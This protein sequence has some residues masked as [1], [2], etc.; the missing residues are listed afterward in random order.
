M[1]V[2]QNL[3]EL[4]NQLSQDSTYREVVRGILTNLE[5][6]SH[7]SIYELADLTSSSRTTIWRML[8]LLGYENYADFRRALK[9][10]VERYS[11]Y[12]RLLPSGAVKSDDRILQHIEK[13]MADASACLGSD[14]ETHPLSKMAK[15]VSEKK[16][17]FFF[18]SYRSPAIYSFQQN[19]A[20]AGIETC[21]VC[22]L[23]DMMSMASLA[24]SDTLV[25][26]SVIEHSETM[27]LVTLF[28]MLYKKKADVVLFAGEESYY[29]E[30][31]GDLIFSERNSTGV[32][33]AIL[34]TDLY[35][36]ALSDTFRKDY[37]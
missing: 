10:A 7:A 28:E 22:L 26:C 2:L 11:Y 4:Y 24:S 33:S 20:M 36:M 9:T 23:P 5:E 16:K 19:L 37:L 35:L 3:I 6:A 13:Q 32:Y 30:L 17:V 31:V 8:K 29:A 12:N 15:K 18:F 25:F 34:R 14:M 1:N 21:A 27:D